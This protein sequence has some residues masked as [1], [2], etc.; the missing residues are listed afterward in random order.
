MVPNMQRDI[1]THQFAVC[2]LVK[3]VPFMVSLI[4]H[5]EIALISKSF[6]TDFTRVLF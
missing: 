5:I 1:F 6:A 4:M 3:N 2:K